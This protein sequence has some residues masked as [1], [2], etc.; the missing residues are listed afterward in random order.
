[1]NNDLMIG[2][3]VPNIG[4][5]KIDPRDYLSIKCDKCGSIIFRNGVILK[6]LPG[7][8]VGNGTEPVTVPLQVLICDKC[9][10]ILKSDIEAYK[11]E[12]E[13]EEE[14]KIITDA[15]PINGENNNSNIIIG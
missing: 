6:E 5:P 11:L 10:S 13:L 9:G 4:G 14:T 15:Q 3:G 12:K 1:M 7:T 2:S 8:L